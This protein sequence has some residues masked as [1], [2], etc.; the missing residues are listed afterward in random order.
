LLAA[1]GLALSRKRRK[2]KSSGCECARRH[3]PAKAAPCW[4]W[5]SS[6]PDRPGR[7]AFQTAHPGSA[8]R[9][10]ALPCPPAAASPTTAAPPTAAD[11]AAPAAD[12]RPS[13][14]GQRRRSERRLHRRQS[15]RR[16]HNCYS[17]RTGRP[18]APGTYSFAK[19][20]SRRRRGLRTLPPARRRPALPRS[21]IET[22]SCAVPLSQ[23][24][25][26]GSNRRVL[27]GQLPPGQPG[28][29]F[30]DAAV[31]EPIM[32]QEGPNGN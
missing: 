22:I 26:N 16:L 17:I 8:A 24:S 5:E 7:L 18:C 21:P 6:V 32:R 2:I 10:L 11:P 23:S 14:S 15:E 1:C 29:P 28:R 12:P 25:Q 20:R 27:R 31:R 4:G 19:C 13:S 9:G 30:G 3:R